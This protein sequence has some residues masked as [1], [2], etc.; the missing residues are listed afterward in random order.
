MK[1]LLV[2][3]LAIL[4]CLSL[5]HI[6]TSAAEG[7]PAGVTPA[8][9]AEYSL[10]YGDKAWTGGENPVLATYSPEEGTI[11]VTYNNEN[12]YF[13]MEDMGEAQ[14]SILLKADATGEY[15]TGTYHPIPGLASRVVSLDDPRSGNERYGTVTIRF[16]SG[17]EPYQY[18]NDA[19]Y[20]IRFDIITNSYHHSTKTSGRLFAFTGSGSGTPAHAESQTEHT[21]PFLMIGY[22]D[23]AGAGGEDPVK[24][25]YS[26]EFGTISVAYVK[27]NIYFSLNDIDESQRSVVLEADSTGCYTQA[28]WFLDPDEQQGS[29]LLKAD[30]TGEYPSGT[31]HPVKGVTSRVVSVGNRR[32]GYDR[33]GT[34]TLRFFDGSEPYQYENDASY[35]VRLDIVAKSLHHSSKMGAALFAFT[36]SGSGTPARAESQT[37]HTAP[38][39]MIGYGDRVGAGGEDPV[40]V[41][42]SPEL[43]T[44]SVAYVKNNN[45]FSLNDIDESQRSVVLEA[46]STG[47]YTQAAWFLDPGEQQGSILLKADT[48]GEY[49]RGTYHPVRGVTSQVVSVGNRRSGNDRYGM[50]TLRFFDGSEPYQYEHEASYAVRFDIVAKNYHYSTKSGAALFAF[51]GSGTGTPESAES[52]T[53]HEAPSLLIGQG[54]RAGAGGENTVKASY[55]PE[56]GAISVAYL[57]DNLFFSLNDIGESLRSVTLESDATGLYNQTAW[58][59]DPGEQQGSILLKADTT[60]D[61]PR[62]TYHPVS[63]VTSRVVSVGN[64]RSGSD[65]YGMITLRF[66]S[67][68]EAYQYEGN[69]SYAVRL[70]I[71]AKGMH[72]SGKPGAALF[73]FTGSGSGTPASAESQTE[74]AAPFL[75]MGQ[76]DRAGAGGEDTIKASYSPELGTISVTYLKDNLFFSLNDIGE[77]RR[78]VTLKSDAT[79]L[80]SPEAWFLDPGEQQGSILLKA[81]TT[82]EYPRGTY[83]PVRG[84]TSR[85]VSVGNRRS[86]NDR[87]GSITLRFLS[88]DEAYQYEG[89]ASYAVR[90][91]IVAK[92]VH[93]SGKPGAAL[94]AFTGSGSGTPA[95]AENNTEHA[96]AFILLGQGDRAGVGGED[97][98]TVKFSPLTGDISV[99]Y[100]R[101][102][103]FFPL[104]DIDESRR[105]ALLELDSS[106]QYRPAAWF[107]DSGERQGSALFKADAAGIYH[108]VPDVASRIVS[109]GN[110]RSGNDYRTVTLRFFNGEEP[111]QY[112]ENSSYIVRLDIIAKGVHHSDK[113][114]AAVFAFT[115]SG[116]ERPLATQSESGQSVAHIL[117]FGDKVGA[118]GEDPATAKFFPRT[119]DISVTYTRDSNCFSLNDIN[120]RQRSVALKIDA[121]GLYRPVTWY[122][123]TG[124]KQGSVLLKADPSGEYQSA[125]D[126][127]P[128]I[129]SVGN[130]RAENDYRTVTLRF[131]NGSDPYQYEKDATYA[132]RFD[133][134]IKGGHHSSKPGAAF[135]FTGQGSSQATP[136]EMEDEPKADASIPDNEGDVRSDG[137]PKS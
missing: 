81:D 38:F 136:N 65:R 30:T 119:G 79:G 110:R 74:H 95:L 14:G 98:A 105:S 35:A 122:L 37:E 49:P 21:A 115:G 39:L 117:G 112:E 68:E 20:A 116:S 59:L 42:Y 83:H 121:A 43:G 75:L 106:G 73:A 17:E 58:F 85:V 90:L 107:I 64:R 102:G 100:A 103:N 9:T 47:C 133:I 3:S 101:D 87:Y 127:T 109:V 63:D 26:P 40:E 93:H 61:Y 25:S 96:A 72:H 66:F 16:F 97:P 71:V 134:V 118:G 24:M 44:I 78:S 36:G 50:M 126:A 104:N 53:E 130:R 111:F 135:A 128:R 11:S 22:G 23:K 6:C 32:S 82:G 80:Y 69:A 55:S 57:K 108:P 62:G 92:G 34:M 45:S 94:F 113:P 48:T 60:G 84:V 89:D 41:S 86:G 51:T 19:S 33:Y 12:I 67:G 131:F 52:Q 88:G 15:P 70:D 31:Y 5:S 27:E 76:G 114:G 7:D 54:D 18:E 4:V 10:V 2:L 28:A 46:D 56:L 132:V 8:V 99:T 123:D 137:N 13:A 124:D 29:I 129:V 77:S 120:E 91:D 1:K 125:P